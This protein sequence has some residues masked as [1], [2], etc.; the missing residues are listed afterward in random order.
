MLGRWTR[1]SGYGIERKSSEMQRRHKTAKEGREVKVW[2]FQFD[3][4]TDLGMKGNGVFDEEGPLDPQY[5]T[6]SKTSK[7]VLRVFFVW[8]M[9]IGC[10]SFCN[11]FS[12]HCLCPCHHL[13]I[14]NGCP[15]HPFPFACKTKKP[16]SRRPH[17]QPLDQLFFFFFEP[18]IF[19]N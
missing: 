14:E 1:R 5:N 3:N 13:F 8:W 11:E 16:N 7:N 19:V 12:L 15:V 18:W 9:S 10:P 4:T 6:S 17:N 2:F